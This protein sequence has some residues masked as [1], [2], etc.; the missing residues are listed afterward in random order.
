MILS[1]TLI[2]LGSLPYLQAL[3]QDL[4]FTSPSS[5]T[6]AQPA[7]LSSSAINGLGKETTCFLPKEY[8]VNFEENDCYP[9]MRSLRS[10]IPPTIS[11]SDMGLLRSWTLPRNNCIISLRTKPLGKH[12]V[13]HDAGV[14]LRA[15]MMIIFDTCMSATTGKGY[16]GTRLINNNPD[17]FLQVNGRA[18]VGGEG[19]AVDSNITAIDTTVSDGEVYGDNV[20]TN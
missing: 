5:P 15:S 19:L 8:P 7:P 20:A 11:S 14:L 16:G 4:P 13:L 2:T 17:F 3:P 12:E 1:S 10:Q 9:V 6:I 18:V